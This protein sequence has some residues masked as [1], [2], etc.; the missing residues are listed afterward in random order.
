MP[1]PAR[2]A[3]AAIGAP[4]S[5]TNTSRAASRIRRSLR[6]AW[7]R[8]PLRGAW[9]FFSIHHI[10]YGT[11]RSVPLHF[12]EQNASFHNALCEL[13]RKELAVPDGT[14]RLRRTMLFGRCLRA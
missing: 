7:A 5:A 12:L 13:R 2:A 1:T 3:T 8:L 9:I 6:A 4:G 10:I 11:K 14:T